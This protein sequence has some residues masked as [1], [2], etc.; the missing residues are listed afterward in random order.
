MTDSCKD[1]ESHPPPV[2]LGVSSADQNVDF[3]VLLMEVIASDLI[4]GNVSGLKQL[5]VIKK[6][7]RDHA[8]AGTSC[9]PQPYL[10]SSCLI[11][12]LF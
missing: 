5:E 2:C 4:T 11:L 8:V 10:H 12:I 7:V 6:P 1:S 9:C 3:G